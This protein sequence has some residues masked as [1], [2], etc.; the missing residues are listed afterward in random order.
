MENI[1]K[2]S[3]MHTRTRSNDS[4]NWERKQRANNQLEAKESKQSM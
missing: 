4:K 2:F 1:E 3:Y